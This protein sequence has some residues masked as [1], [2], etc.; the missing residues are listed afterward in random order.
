MAILT[1]LQPKTFIDLAIGVIAENAN[2][3]GISFITRLAEN[4]PNSFYCDKTKLTQILTTLA[5][6]AV[7]RTD[8][9]TVAIQLKMAESSDQNIN[10]YLT[11]SVED[12]G[13]GVDTDSFSQILN[14]EIPVG[15]WPQEYS[16]NDCALSLRMASKLVGILGGKLEVECDNT[17]PTTR[18]FFTI[19]VKLDSGIG[20]I[21][22]NNSNP[23]PTAPVLAT[24]VAAAPLPEKTETVEVKVLIVDDVPENR[25]LVDVLLKKMGCKTSFAANG[26]EAVDF[27]KKEKLDVILMDIQMPVLNG[28]E[29]TRKIREDGLNTRATIIAMTASG[30]KSDDF[31]A[32]DAGCDDCLAKPVDRKKLERKLWR[33]SAQLKQFNDADS[34]KSIVS[35]LEGDPDYQKAIET[36]I[37]NLPSRIDEIKNAYEQGDTKA[38]AF[39]VHALKGL[40][41]F[42]GFPIFTEKAKVMEQSIKESHVDKLQTQVE[43]LVQLCLRTKLKDQASL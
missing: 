26:Q 23:A 15:R 33:V 12:M 39:K 4:L 11:F 31:A 1:K 37:D 8:K 28:L 20:I 36:F 25:M 6:Q 41:G 24:P 35:F 30:Q 16:N 10:N 17:A 18:F 21:S 38:L 13:C 9:G 14:T 3:K 7:H 32:L 19:P 27:C 29:A 43:E 34:G 2:K 42:A 22:Q 5:D 40:G